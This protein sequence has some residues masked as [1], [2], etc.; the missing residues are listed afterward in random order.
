MKLIPTP[1]QGAAG[2]K[3]GR[4]ADQ[5]T[6]EHEYVRISDHGEEAQDDRGKTRKISQGRRAR[7][8]FTSQEKPSCGFKS[9][10][11]RK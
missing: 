4:S 10:L 1:L 6:N 5:R 8:H 11:A 9:C 7:G 2:Q 3:H